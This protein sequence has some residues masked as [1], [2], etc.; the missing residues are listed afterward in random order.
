MWAE[1]FTG[2]VTWDDPKITLPEFCNTL[3]N[4]MFSML[5]ITMELDQS[6]KKDPAHAVNGVALI[7][8]IKLKWVNE[9]VFFSTCPLARLWRFTRF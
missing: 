5:D 3:Y 9:E 8:T 6:L 4:K 2:H 7:E 1:F